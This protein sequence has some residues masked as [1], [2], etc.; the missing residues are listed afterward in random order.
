[1]RKEKNYRRFI[2]SFHEHRVE[3]LRLRFDK[4]ILRFVYYPII[5]IILEEEV[6]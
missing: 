3:S 2:C 1:L 6:Q 5:G 4:M